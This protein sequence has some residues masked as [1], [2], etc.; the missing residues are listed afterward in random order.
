MSNTLSTQVLI[1]GAGPTGLMAANQL[2]RFGINFIIIDK[3]SGPTME[4]R[5][6]AVTARS[7]E[8]YQQMGLSDQVLD[9]GQTITQAS[10]YNRGKSKARIN[11][12]ELGK[13]LSDFSYLLAFEQ[14]KNETLLSQNLSAQGHQVHWQHELISLKEYKEQ[15]TA[16]AKYENNEITIKA[17]Y[18]IACDGATSPVRHQL[19]FSFEGGTYDHKFFVADTELSWNI[20]AEQLLIAPGSKSFSAF[21]PLKG[22]NKYRV[23]GTLPKHYATKTDISF[24]DLEESVKENIGIDISFNKVNW[25]SIY[26]LHHRM[27]DQFKKHRVFLAGDSAHIHSPAGGQGMNTGLQDAYNL[28]WKLAAVLKKQANSQLLESYNEERLPF[29]K[30]LLRFT[31]QGFSTMTKTDPLTNFFRQNLVLNVINSLIKSPFVRPLIFKTI[32][33][34]RY[35]YHRFSLS[36]TFSKQKLKFKSGERLPYFPGESIYPLFTKATFHLLHIGNQALEQAEIDK[37]EQLFPFPITIVENPINN[38]WRALGVKKP[39]FLLVR[40]DNYL[41]LISDSIQKA[42]VQKFLS[43]A[44]IRP[45]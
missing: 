6:I 21:L 31:D 44:R 14:S 3:K 15:I 1:S 36:S 34:T 23:I 43:K 25:F 10:I 42:Q 20:D 19:G 29:A 38:N 30:W 9:D 2:A 39:L 12:G 24:Q 32:S 35:D 26:Q 16:I 45:T 17:D 4:S 8:I 5:A 22:D 41:S 7:L 28:C 11:I 37:I 27:V 18:L 40:P 33:Q 13:G